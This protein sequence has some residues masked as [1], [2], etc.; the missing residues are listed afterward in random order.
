M[1]F[2]VTTTGGSAGN[3]DG[4]YSVRMRPITSTIAS[5]WPEAATWHV[6]VSGAADALIQGNVLPLF[7]DVVAW[8]RSDA[9]QTMF[10]ITNALI[11]TGNLTR[12]WALGGIWSL[13]LFFMV[14]EAAILVPS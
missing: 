2:R 8:L 9:R 7:I 12:L 11:L 1:L 10:G 5:Q 14:P 13:P 3:S 4:W 6:A